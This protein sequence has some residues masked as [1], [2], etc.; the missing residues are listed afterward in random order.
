MQ[1]LDKTWIRSGAWLTLMLL[2]T[3]CMNVANDKA[4]C[5]GTKIARTDHAAALAQDGGN[6]SVVTGAYLIQLLDKGCREGR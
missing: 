3:G 5:D 4:I 2:V 1:R 6:T